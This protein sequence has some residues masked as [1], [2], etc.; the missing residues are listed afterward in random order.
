MKIKNK[1]A[2]EISLEAVIFIV[3]NVVFFV[4]LL[5]FVSRLGGSEGMKEEVYA[6]KIALVIDNMKSNMEV[7][8]SIK[9]IYDIKKSQIN[10]P[11]VRIEENQVIVKLGEMKG[12]SFHFF[13]D[14]EPRLYFYKIKEDYILTIKT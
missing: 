10:E 11:I 8:I 6:K 14:V 7:N 3:L 2:E 4:S 12:Y 1:K 13:S 9:E 5:F